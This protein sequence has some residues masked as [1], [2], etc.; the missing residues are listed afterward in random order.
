MT[1]N[2]ELTQSAPA[3]AKLEALR[4]RELEIARLEVLIAKDWEQYKTRP[5]RT[6]VGETIRDYRIASYVET[7]RQHIERFAEANYPKAAT[8]QKI[9]GNLIATVAIRADGTLESVRVDRSSGFMVLDSATIDI[10]N[11]AAPFE[12]FT[13][14]MRRDIDV[15]HITRRSTFTRESLMKGGAMDQ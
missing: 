13:Q 4:A 6:Y 11:R 3:I 7:W 9:Y 5:Y 15:L 2:R 14:E 10:V 12:P 1:P 8:E